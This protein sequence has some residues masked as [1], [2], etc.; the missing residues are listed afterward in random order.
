MRTGPAELVLSSL[1]VTTCVAQE[2]LGFPLTKF[3]MR[4]GTSLAGIDLYSSTVEQLGVRFGKATRVCN[5]AKSAAL[6]GERAIVT[7][8]SLRSG[9]R[10]KPLT[11]VGPRQ[12]VSLASLGTV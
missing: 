3:L 5:R 1:R 6:N 8:E 10:L 9:I 4:T 12:T 7:L 11:F 2:C